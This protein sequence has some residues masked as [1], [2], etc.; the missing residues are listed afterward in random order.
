MAPLDQSAAAPRGKV[1]RKLAL[2]SGRWTPSMRGSAERRAMRSMRE[3]QDMRE[4]AG[5]AVA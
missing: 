2:A 5:D 1:A 4:D 3:A